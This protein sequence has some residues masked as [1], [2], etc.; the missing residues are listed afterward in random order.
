MTVLDN[1]NLYFRL[2][3]Y[4]ITK[5]GTLDISLANERNFSITKTEESQSKSYFW[6]M[7]IVTPPTFQNIWSMPSEE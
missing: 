7:K 4:R 3:F 6:K 5:V 1:I 2:F